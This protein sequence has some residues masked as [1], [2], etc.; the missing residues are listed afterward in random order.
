MAYTFR[1]GT[2]EQT[3]S[4]NRAL[5]NRSHL[6]F[7]FSEEND[8]IKRVFLPM[9]ENC[10]ITESQNSNLG[11]YSLI[12]RNNNLFSYTSSKSREFKVSFL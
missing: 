2:E 1:E 6:L 5:E 4:I 7:E 10:Q 8:S 11:E 12:G 9:L 3:K